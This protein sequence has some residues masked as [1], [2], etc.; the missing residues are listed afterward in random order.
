MKTLLPTLF[1][2]LACSAS[3]QA[4]VITVNATETNGGTLPGSPSEYVIFNGS[5]YNKIGGDAAGSY[6]NLPDFEIVGGEYERSGDA[7]FST[8]STP[9]GASSLLTGSI[10]STNTIAV[11]IELLGSIS[12][13]GLASDGFN[14]N[15]FNIYVMVDNAPGDSSYDDTSLALDARL[16]NT[17]L[18]P[19]DFTITSQNTSLSSADYVEYNVTG[20]GT[21]VAAEEALHP[22]TNNDLVLRVFKPDGKFSE[23][24]ALGFESAPEPS[25]WAMLFTGVVA[26][27][28]VA[29]RAKSSAR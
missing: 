17:E 13:G 5:E 23:F 12:P 2:L 29:R 27:F 25:T 28:F 20:L 16:D 21:A 3:A 4:Q 8:I 9:G 10:S 26:L 15:D 11:G 7:G 22:S 19:T 14:F 24:G 6:K 18:T 1:A